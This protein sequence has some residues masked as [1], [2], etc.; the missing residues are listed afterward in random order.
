MELWDKMSETSSL[1]LRDHICIRPRLYIGHFG[2]G[3]TYES[4]L[5]DMLKEILNNSVDE[6]RMTGENRIE[7]TI[8]DG[9]VATIRDYGRGIPLEELIH[10]HVNHMGARRKTRRDFEERLI[11]PA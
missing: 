3:S 1:T 4:G 7:V 8:N 2:D 11:Q 9:R 5:Y 6:F 10:M